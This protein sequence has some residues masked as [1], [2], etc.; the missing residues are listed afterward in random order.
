[1]ITHPTRPES[2]GHSSEVAS[3]VHVFDDAGDVCLLTGQC[4]V[5]QERAISRR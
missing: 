5:V 1:M 3:S 2:G 4:P